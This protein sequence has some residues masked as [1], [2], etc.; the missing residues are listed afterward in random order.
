MLG[1]DTLFRFPEINGPFRGSHALA[2]NWLTT[3]QLRSTLLVRLFTDV[4]L[5]RAME[6]THRLRCLGASLIAPEQAVLTGLSAA[7]VH[8][9]DLA[10]ANDP[11]EFA[12]PTSIRFGAQ[13]GIDVRRVPVHPGEYE[14][15]GRVG[16]ATP[17]RLTLDVLTNTRL[18]RSLPRTVGLLDALLRAEFVDKKSLELTLA[19]RHDHGIVRAR[20]AMELADPRSESIPESEVRVWLT[21]GGVKPDVQVTV[22]DEFGC[23]LG[24]LD[25]AYVL[26]KLAVEYDGLWHEQGRQP[27]LDEE[28]RA[29]LRAAGWDFIVITKELLYGDPRGM[30]DT[31]RE[32]LRR[33]GST[34]GVVEPQCRGNG[35]LGSR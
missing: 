32:A 12:V 33:R 31:V 4:Y 26:D 15:W 25:L 22:Y 30:V 20:S 21:L 29:R 9:L 27:Q 16:L 14:P 28:R 18:R 10:A 17:L 7:A 1:V 35:G 23:H 11:V 13:R 3:R 8:G 19:Q 5:P 24:R 2:E 34:T 6:P